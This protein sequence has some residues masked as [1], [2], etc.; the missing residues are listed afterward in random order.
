MVNMREVATENRLSHWSGII[1]ERNASG[2]SIKAYCESIGVRLNV[3]YYWQRKLRGAAYEE[4]LSATVSSDNN[5]KNLNSISA[6]THTWAVCE[7]ATPPSA[8]GS[9][10]TVTIEIGKSRVSANTGTDMNHLSNICRMLM[11]LC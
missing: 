10:A 7:V 5:A 6:N 9:A 11:S 1:R 3:Y 2:L 8:E 4:A